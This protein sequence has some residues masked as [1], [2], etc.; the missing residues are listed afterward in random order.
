MARPAVT[1][2]I[3]LQF[4]MTLIPLIHTGIMVNYIKLGENC[5]YKTY[6]RSYKN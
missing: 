4:V 1:V 5:T 3:K 2:E 6:K